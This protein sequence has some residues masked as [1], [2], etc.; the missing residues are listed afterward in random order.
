MHE[1]A[2]HFASG[3]ASVSEVA[4]LATALGGSGEVVPRVDEAFVDIAST[5]GPGSLTTLLAPLFACALGACVSKVGV[6]GRPAGGLDVLGS[7]PGYTVSVDLARARRILAAG[8]YLHVGAGDSFCPLDAVLFD[9]R[10]RHGFQA[11]RDLAIASLLAKKLAAGV[12]RAV[13]DVRVGSHGNFGANRKEASLNSC[14]LVEVATTL[15][16]EAVCAIRA[17][18]LSQPFLGRGE[19]AYALTTVLRGDA[20]GLLQAHALDCLRLAAVA[21]GLE[22]PHPDLSSVLP[23]ALSAHRTMLVAHG[24]DVADFDARVSDFERTERLVLKADRDG[25][26]DI[27]LHGVRSAIVARQTQSVTSSVRFPDPCGVEV[28]AGLGEWVHAGQPVVSTRA[29]TDPAGFVDE[30]TRS[31]S[32]TDAAPSIGTDETEFIRG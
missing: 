1:L 12:T 29:E 11:V 16:I 27:D 10:Q 25:R 31:V 8:R 5:G 32:I 4:Q 2:S 24:A 23:G 15:G 22:A 3:S 17:S 30:L 21:G 26:F 14:R 28:L 7:L 6:P 19:A 20:S 9:W 18:K 13:F